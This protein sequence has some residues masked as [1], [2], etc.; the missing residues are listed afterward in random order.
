MPR[1]LN[2]SLRALRQLPGQ[3]PKEPVT[4]TLLVADVAVSE[5]VL[6]ADITVTDSLLVADIV[7]ITG[8][9]LVADIVVRETIVGDMQK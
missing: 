6:N 1:L 9:L 7:A 4:Q 5:K 2:S 8:I 3:R